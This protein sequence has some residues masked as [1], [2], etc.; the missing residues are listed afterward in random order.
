MY[1]FRMSKDEVNRKV[2]RDFLLETD[3]R[4]IDSWVGVVFTEDAHAGAKRNSA[5]RCNGL[6]V[7]PGRR[8]RGS[9]KAGKGEGGVT[10]YAKLLRAIVSD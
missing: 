6:D 2:L 9:A 10:E 8:L 7:G 3:I 1:G 5:T 4:S